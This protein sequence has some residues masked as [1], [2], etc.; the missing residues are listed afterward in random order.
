MR[1]PHPA[2][3]IRGQRFGGHRGPGGPVVIDGGLADAGALA[4]GID[5][6]AG[7]ALVMQDLSSRGEHG[8]MGANTAWSVKLRTAGSRGRAGLGGR[9]SFGTHPRIKS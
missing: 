3:H 9:G 4:D 5:R 6:R 8:F 2:S 1:N 7:K